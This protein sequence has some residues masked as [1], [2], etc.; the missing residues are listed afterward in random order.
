MKHT[1]YQPR[2]LYDPE[3]PETSSWRVAAPDDDNR[4]T[5]DTQEAAEEA[6]DDFLTENSYAVNRIVIAKIT[7]EVEY[8]QF[9]SEVAT[10][11]RGCA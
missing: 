7:T 1:F 3:H 5:F 9:G 11:F 10:L 2:M 8:L 6:A 4:S